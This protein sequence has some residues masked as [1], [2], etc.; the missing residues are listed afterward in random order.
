MEI[1][2]K[3]YLEKVLTWKSWG[4]HHKKLVWAIKEL[5]HE[6]EK[7]KARLTLANAE[8]EVQGE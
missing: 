6:N 4:Q 2:A 8:S 7:L 1:H 5:I 3:D